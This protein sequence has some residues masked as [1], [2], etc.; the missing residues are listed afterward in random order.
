MPVQDW[1][2]H[3]GD[4][5]SL[6]E[7]KKLTPSK[8]IRATAHTIDVLYLGTVELLK[9]RPVSSY[10]TWKMTPVES[11]WCGVMEWPFF[12]CCSWD[13]SHSLGQQL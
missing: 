4:T 9:V 12:S 2:R 10:R 6:E 8:S 1:H 5:V 11:Y 3:S 7:H 13:S